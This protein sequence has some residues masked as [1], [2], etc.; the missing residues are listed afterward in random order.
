MPDFLRL[1]LGFGLH[2]VLAFGLQLCVLLRREH[3]F[4]SVHE[5]VHALLRAAGFVAFVLSSVQPGLLLRCEIHLGEH[6]RAISFAPRHRGAGT[7]GVGR[8]C[9]EQQSSE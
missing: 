9:S 2:A 6:L 3:A 7:P 5:F 8:G 4:G 1:Q